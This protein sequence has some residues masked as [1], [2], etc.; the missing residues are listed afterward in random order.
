M[1]ED[2]FVHCVHMREIKLNLVNI[3]KMS[4]PGVSCQLAS[5]LL[6]SRCA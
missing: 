1:K 4:K 2:M 6:K 3:E 5:A